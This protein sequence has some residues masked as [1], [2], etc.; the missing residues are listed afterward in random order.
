L[1]ILKGTG[2]QAENHKTVKVHYK[3]TFLNGRVFDSSYDRNEPIEFKLG[4]RQVI[5]GWEE[6]IMYMNVGG[7]AK[8]ILPSQIAYGESGAG[9][10]II[11]PFC[12]LVFEVELIE[13]K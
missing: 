10:G 9:G 6:G 1:E 7:K 12:P 4:E 13:V 11:P 3:G 5:P 8:L 2:A